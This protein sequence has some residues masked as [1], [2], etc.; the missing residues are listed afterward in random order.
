MTTSSKTKQ[1]QPASIRDTAFATIP[2]WNIRAAILR[3]LGVK[4]LTPG[5]SV[6]GAT[7]SRPD[8]VHHVEA[9]IEALLL[10][11]KPIPAD[12]GRPIIDAEQADA[13]AVARAQAIN[14]VA[15]SYA[16]TTALFTEDSTEEAFAYLAS[17]L[18]SLVAQVRE[19]SVNLAGITSPDDAITS[20]PDV[21]KS[22]Q[23]VAALEPDYNEI[24]AAQ[25]ELLKA[26]VDQ[27]STEINYDTVVHSG[28]FRRAVESVPYWIDR[29]RDSANL[30]PQNSSGLVSDYQAW[31]RQGRASAAFQPGI[32]SVHRLVLFC[33]ELSPYLATGAEL[34][35]QRAAAWYITQR[36]TTNDVQALIDT[37]DKYLAGQQLTDTTPH[38]RSLTPSPEREARLE[39]KAAQMRMRNG[40]QLNGG[41]P[42]G[43]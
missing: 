40:V 25:Y 22:W 13:L 42:L 19:E 27:S 17:R 21:I 15:N 31:L 32:N 43:Y 29:R 35:Q 16:D 12:V 34:E 37:R 5:V 11:D 2:G 23:I 1:Q 9:E 20:G 26:T 30:V 38:G 41:L 36:P 10:A 28:Q 4:T 18:D 24:R 33:T 14:S 3:Q 7:L 39:H 6:T 8:A